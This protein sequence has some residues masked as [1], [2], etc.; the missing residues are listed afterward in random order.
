MSGVWLF[1]NPVYLR[2]CSLVGSSCWNQPLKS[3]SSGAHRPAQFVIIEKYGVFF[4]RKE[5]LVYVSLGMA[6][7]HV[8]ADL[9]YSPYHLGLSAV[10]IACPVRKNQ[11]FSQ[12]QLAMFQ[13]FGP[14]SSPQSKANIGSFCIC[15]LISYGWINN[16]FMLIRI[17]KN[18]VNAV[19]Y[20]VYFAQIF[21]TINSVLCSYISYV[22]II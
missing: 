12:C 7:A 14:V 2:W 21:Y 20:L 22:S 9:L 16:S 3:R 11:H 17:M 5:Y 19:A 10:S 1:E 13:L 15:I 6:V 4:T 18:C 8:L